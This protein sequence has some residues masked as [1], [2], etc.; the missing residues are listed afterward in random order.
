MPDRTDPLLRTDVELVE[1]VLA[2]DQSAFRVLVERY[3]DPLFRFLYRLTGNR[4]LAEDVFQDAFLQVHQSLGTFDRQRQFK[5]WLFT[6]AANKGRDALRRANRR[7]TVSLSGSRG[8]DD[9]PGFDFA[10]LRGV[11]P[12]ERLTSEEL[13]R[14]VQNAIDELPLRLREILLLAYFQK[15]SYAQMSEAFGIPIGTVKSRLHAA[16]AAFAKRWQAQLLAFEEG[17]SR[18]REPGS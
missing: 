13:N 4:D 11:T 3:H 7:A 17:T 18:N 1:D 16:V 15:L 12:D 6:I 8:D 10:D 2:G 5:P 14:L 9:S